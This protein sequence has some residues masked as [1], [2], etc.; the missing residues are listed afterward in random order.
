MVVLNNSSDDAAQITEVEQNEALED[1]VVQSQVIDV[2]DPVIEQDA[3]EAGP[4]SEVEESPP[5]D[6]GDNDARK[7]DGS[8][9]KRTSKRKSIVYIVSIIPLIHPNI[10][11]PRC[12]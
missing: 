5:N 4:I 8:P 9:I 6:G 2:D 1:V 7:R 10:S 3:V 11:F 12:C